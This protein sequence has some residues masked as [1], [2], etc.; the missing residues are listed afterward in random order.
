M[1]VT[2]GLYPDY[3]VGQWTNRCDPLSALNW[4]LGTGKCTGNF[5]LYIAPASGYVIEILNHPSQGLV[6][7]L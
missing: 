2:S 7:N 5:S 4:V 6:E 3:S 1:W